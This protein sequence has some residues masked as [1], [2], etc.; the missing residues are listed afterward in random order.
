ME[1]YHYYIVLYLGYMLPVPISSAQD[2]NGLTSFLSTRV[3]QSSIHGGTELLCI[4]NED[5]T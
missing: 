1:Q 5:K 4:T 3:D 2:G